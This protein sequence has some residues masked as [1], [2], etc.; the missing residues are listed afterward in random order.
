MHDLIVLLKLAGAQKGCSNSLSK[1]MERS[2]YITVSKYVGSDLP[3]INKTLKRLH[4]YAGKLTIDDNSLR[5]Q[6]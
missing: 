1:I 3:K 6:L 2:K 4:L 5:M